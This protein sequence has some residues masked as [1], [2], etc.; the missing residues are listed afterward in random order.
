MGKFLVLV[1]NLMVLIA[2]LSISCVSAW[3]LVEEHLY[4]QAATASSPYSLSSLVLLV[5]GVTVTL[6]AFTGCC[7][8]ILQSRCLLGIYAAFLLLLV[9]AK[10]SFAVLILLQQVD[11]SSLIPENL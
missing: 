7:G 5:I 6:V 10:I 8:A 1:V 3:L 11:Y 2:G 9:A 4:L